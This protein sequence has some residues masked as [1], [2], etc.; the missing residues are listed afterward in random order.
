MDEREDAQDA[1]AEL[2]ALVTHL[3]DH[4]PSETCLFASSIDS[5]H[6]LR[7][8]HRVQLPI[9]HLEVVLAILI[10][11]RFRAPLQRRP[12]RLVLEQPHRLRVLPSQISS[13]PSSRAAACLHSPHQW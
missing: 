3:I 7:I 6:P 11:V 8:R 1:D 2:S 5:R 12:L 13:I 9:S 4:N 10:R